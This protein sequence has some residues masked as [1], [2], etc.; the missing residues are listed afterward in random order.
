[1]GRSTEVRP[2]GANARPICPQPLAR[3]QTFSRLDRVADSEDA[4]KAL[5]HTA[6]WIKVADAKAGAVLAAGSVLGGLLVREIAQQGAW[7]QHPWGASLSLV[8]LALVSAS[9]LLSLRVFTP[10]LKAAAPRSLLY[11]DDIARHYQQRDQFTADYVALLSEQD[12]LSEAL[13]GQLWE[14]SRVASQKHRCMT[15]AILLLGSAVLIS[16]I[17]G[18]FSL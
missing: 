15:K 16:I 4:W 5:A 8:G 10:R 11:F 17:A 7:R 2:I 6:D 14:I 18:L 3:A 12:R 1:M 13:A 9:I